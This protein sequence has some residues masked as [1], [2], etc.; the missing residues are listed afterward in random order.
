M[1]D[2]LCFD[3]WKLK[4]NLT[5]NKWVPEQE[6]LFFNLEQ[7]AHLFPLDDLEWRK[8]VFRFFIYDLSS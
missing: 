5:I 8:L 3:I 6:A 4:L 2:I 7:I 1:K